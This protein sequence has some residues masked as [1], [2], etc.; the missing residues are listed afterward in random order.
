MQHI[1]NT[2]LAAAHA[3]MHMMN[4][5]FKQRLQGAAEI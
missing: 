1:W 4:S 2:W 5:L 3:V